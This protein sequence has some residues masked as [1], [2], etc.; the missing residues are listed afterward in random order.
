MSDEHH[1]RGPGAPEEETSLA[2]E[3]VNA[4]VATFAAA[5]RKA[6]AWL[7]LENL[8]AFVAERTLCRSRAASALEQATHL[9]EVEQ[10]RIDFALETARAY[11]TLALL[12]QAV[13]D[14]AADRPAKPG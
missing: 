13:V 7:A 3:R 6:I 5:R 4:E 8:E 9:D 14:E 2:I 10:V 11:A 12:F 1:W